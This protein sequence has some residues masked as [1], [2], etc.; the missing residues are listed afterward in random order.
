MMAT[1][2]TGAMEIV[3]G[4]MFGGME[5]MGPALIWCSFAD[6]GSAE[7]A[8]GQLLDEGL[9]ACANILPPMRSLYR[10][11][12]ERGAGVETGVLF[13]TNAALLERATGR[14]AE[15]H[16]YD[17]PAILGWRTDHASPAT[18]A[19]LAELAGAMLQE[20]PDGA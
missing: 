4:G 17:E 8:A 9:V 6:A 11:R 10:W 12:G 3:N 1:A 2:S 16:P 19:W 13:K 14:L 15:L 20:L 5:A 7:R 18:A